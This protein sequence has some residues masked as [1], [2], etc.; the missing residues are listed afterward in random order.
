MR[1]GLDFSLLAKE[2]AAARPSGRPAAA[3]R[4]D[5]SHAFALPS[6]TAAG[7]TSSALAHREIPAR[8]HP[9]GRARAEHPTPPRRADPPNRKEAL[10]NDKAQS[11]YR[12]EARDGPRHTDRAKRDDTARSPRSTRRE[13]APRQIDAPGRARAEQPED[14]PADDPTSPPQTDAGGVP[15]DAE[16]GP[17]KTAQSDPA[18]T[19]EEPDDKAA[20]DQQGAVAPDGAVPPLPPGA[21]ASQQGGASPD[22]SAAVSALAVTSTTAAQA[23]G[24]SAGAGEAEPAEAGLIVTAGAAGLQ[25]AMAAIEGQGRELPPGLAKKLEEHGAAEKSETS[26]SDPPPPGKADALP[27]KALEAFEKSLDAASAGAPAPSQAGPSKIETGQLG[28]APQQAHAAASQIPVL[29][30]VPLGSV[31]IEIG[32]KSL[33]GVNRF[34]I[35]LDPAEL[36]RIDVRL[37]IGDGGEVKAHLVVDRVETLALLQRDAKTLERAFEQAG[38]KPS[39][40][41]IDLSLRDP[42]GDRRGGDQPQGDRGQPPAGRPDGIA[43]PEAHEPVVAP[44]RI[45]WRSTGGVD[46]RI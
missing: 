21:P 42:S 25:R 44:R 3:V 34:E 37:D 30:Q 33:A 2:L 31:P 6:E 41:G 43:A 20:Q 38:L 14:V 22:L 39:E 9:D 29:Q 11:P 24:P 23:V 36:G 15:A 5:R 18:G 16:Q 35:R 8:S 32:L 17:A 13:D 27:S 10:R 45:S 28:Q 19:D 46:L 26:V 4:L 7:S 1:N 12:T 40:G